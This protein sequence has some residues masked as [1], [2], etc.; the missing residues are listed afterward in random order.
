MATRR[1]IEPEKTPE[2][3]ASISA[4]YRQFVADFGESDANQVLTA[5]SHWRERARL[6]DYFVDCLAVGIAYGCF[7][8]FRDKHGFRR[9]VD[10]YVD[11]MKKYVDFDEYR[12]DTYKGEELKESP[13]KI[14]KKTFAAHGL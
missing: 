13:L 6:S 11:W 9:T 10:E 8:E 12:A 14:Y 2:E 1:V 7:T 4:T 3:V 5:G